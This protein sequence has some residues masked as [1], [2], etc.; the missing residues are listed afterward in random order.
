MQHINNTHTTSDSRTRLLH[1]DSTSLRRSNMTA[2]QR[3]AQNTRRRDQR[4]FREAQQRRISNVVGM[5]STFEIGESSTA[6]TTPIITSQEL[7]QNL[8]TPGTTYPNLA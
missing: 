6:T 5:H 1:R 3:A 2:Q 8:L 4:H 7:L